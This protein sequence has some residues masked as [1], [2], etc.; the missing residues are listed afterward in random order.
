M[1]KQQGTVVGFQVGNNRVPGSFEIDDSDTWIR[2]RYAQPKSFPAASKFSSDRTRSL[3]AF[4]KVSNLLLENLDEV[5][6]NVH[7]VGGAN[8][9]ERWGQSSFRGGF[10]FCSTKVLGC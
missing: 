8:L 7:N 3:L 1:G 4:R 6:V 10:V 2:W 5:R 9:R